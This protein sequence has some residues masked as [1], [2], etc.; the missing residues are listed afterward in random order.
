MLQNGIV[1][2]PTQGVAA[3]S[4]ELDQRKTNNI[5]IL[6]VFVTG[7]RRALKQAQH[8]GGQ[9]PAGTHS[10]RSGLLSL[11]SVQDGIWTLDVAIINV[12]L[13]L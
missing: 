9:R 10:L 5:L 13:H 3:I 12:N 1:L 7:K 8:T 6:A 4:S 2:T 11:Q